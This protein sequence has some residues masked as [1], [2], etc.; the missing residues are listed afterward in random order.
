MQQ[1]HFPLACFS[2]P[3]VVRRP[4]LASIDQGTTK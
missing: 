2:S 3:F 1:K 4:L